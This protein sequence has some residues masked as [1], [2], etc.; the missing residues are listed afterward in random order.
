MSRLRESRELGRVIEAAGGQLL[1]ATRG[2][3]PKYRLP[4]GKVVTLAK[5]ASD[6]R[7]HKNLIAR[8]RREGIEIPH[9]GC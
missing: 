1:P 8:L 3:H 7:T 6:H 9:R 2:G 4:N 5:T